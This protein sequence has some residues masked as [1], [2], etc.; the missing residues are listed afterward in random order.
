[1]KFTLSP[2]RRDDTVSYR[3]AGDTLSVDGEV[4][5]FSKVGEGDILPR[6]AIKSEWFSGDVIR[7]N[8]E[9]QLA[10]ILPNPWNYS[11]AQAFPVPI[12]VTKN[13]LVELPGPLPVATEGATYEQY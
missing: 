9:L 4:F 7:V 13:G 12:T 2:Q 1:M 8:G 11:Q 5:D 10:L 3:K 6:N